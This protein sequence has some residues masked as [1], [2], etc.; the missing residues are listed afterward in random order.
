MLQYLR[1]P[2]VCRDGAEFRLP[3]FKL[4]HGRQVSLAAEMRDRGLDPRRD[5]TGI[6]LLA[7]A[8]IDRDFLAAQPAVCRLA[9]PWRILQQGIEVLPAQ[10]P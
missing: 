7:V 9:Q 2:D 8:E 5:L 4:H 6:H 10:C 3:A 1:M